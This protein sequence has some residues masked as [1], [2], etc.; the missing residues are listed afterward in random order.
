MHVSI[1]I[2]ILVIAT[3]FVVIALEIYS[4]WPQIENALAFRELDREPRKSKK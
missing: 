3:A 4:R 1:V 2:A